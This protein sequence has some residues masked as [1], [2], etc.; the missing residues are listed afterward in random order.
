M[1]GKSIEKYQKLFSLKGKMSV[2]TGAYGYLGSAISKAL[3]GFGANVILVGRNEQKLKD[4]VNRNQ[5]SPFYHQGQFETYHGGVDPGWIRAEIQKGAH[6]NNCDSKRI[7]S[8]RADS[9]QFL[10]LRYQDRIAVGRD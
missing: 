1:S 7:G 10:A 4:F 2:V 8:T 3:A 6:Q 9:R 5:K